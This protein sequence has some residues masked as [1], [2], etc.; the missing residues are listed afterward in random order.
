VKGYG[1]A[2][3]VSKPDCTK[4]LLQKLEGTDFV[5]K[6]CEGWKN[7]EDLKKKIDKDLEIVSKRVTF[8]LKLRKQVKEFENDI[9]TNNPKPQEQPTTTV[10][11]D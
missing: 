7:L 9:V 2:R 3:D 1:Y 10:S 6:R 8:L 11:N 5:Y 4:F